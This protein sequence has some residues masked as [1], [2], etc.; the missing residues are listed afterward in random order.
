MGSVTVLLVVLIVL[1]SI[2]CLPTVGSQIIE[3]ELTVV[4]GC[5]ERIGDDG[6]DEEEF[7]RGVWEDSANREFVLQYCK[8]GRL[9]RILGIL[10]CQYPFGYHL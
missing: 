3:P 5:L 1:T 6:P 10:P 9:Q 4:E 2:S 8:S 7:L